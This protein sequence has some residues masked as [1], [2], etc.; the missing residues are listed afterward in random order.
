ME[1]KDTELIDSYLSGDDNALKELIGK[2]TPQIYN[3]V[4]RFVGVNEADDITQ[5]VF[6]KVWKNLKKFNVD[7]SSFKTWIFTIA[8]NTVIDFM[9]KRKIV[10]FSSLDNEENFSESIEDEAIL[11]DEVI[12]KLQD[13]DLLNSLLE[14]LPEQYRTVLVL[15]YQEDMTFDEISQVLNKPS[16]TVKSHHL[17][18]IS[19][20]RRMIA[21]K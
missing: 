5:E 9:R 10:L 3:F 16:N 1:N 17:R 7:K 15:H 4:R 20:L 6:I 2:Y 11:P 21:P 13:V 14:K 12:Q 19:Q 8:R 18:A